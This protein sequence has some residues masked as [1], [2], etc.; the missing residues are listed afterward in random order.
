MPL[1][2][3]KEAIK[4]EIIAAF[5][6]LSRERP[7]TD[8]SLR[9]I[10]A[11]A[12][13]S[14]TKV[15]RYFHSK[16]ELHEASVHWA[17]NAAKQ[18]ITRWFQTHS[19]EDYDSDRAFLDEFFSDLNYDDYGFSPRNIVMTCAL[20]AYSDNIRAAVKE[21]YNSIRE[22]LLST[23]EEALGKPLDP[24]VSYALLVLFNGMYF[25]AFNEG[26]PAQKLLPLEKFAELAEK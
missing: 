7:L 20:G 23:V 18:S 11:E 22:L 19:R 10:A 26:V 6:R 14:H 13:M 2:V 9:E 21:E 17:G 12:G 8:V 5:E 16:S 15:L 4:I 25:T 3:D 24:A 1:I